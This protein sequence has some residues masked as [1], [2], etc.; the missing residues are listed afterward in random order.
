[1]DRPLT[2]GN[3]HNISLESLQNESD[4]YSH[5]VA[6]FSCEAKEHTCVHLY[7]HQQYEHDFIV[8][9]AAV[10]LHDLY[11]VTVTESV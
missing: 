6:K 7:W 10:W 2:I 5:L 4:E 9:C 8:C 1:M 11:N 3:V